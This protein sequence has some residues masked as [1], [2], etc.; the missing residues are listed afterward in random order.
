MEKR[1]V[2]TKV[3][4]VVGIVLVWFPLVSP[5]V[6]SVFAYITEQIFRFDFLMPAELFPVGL[7][8]GGVLLWASLRAHTLRGLI[9]WGLGIAVGLLIGG[10]ALAVGTGLASGEAESNSWIRTLVLA[11]IGAYGVAMAITGIGGVLL[12][13]EALKRG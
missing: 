5:M 11:S 9:G 1:D 4:T 3:L 13:R 10:Q 2:L 7:L 6:F 8:G 12:L